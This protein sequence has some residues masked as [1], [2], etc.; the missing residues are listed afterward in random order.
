MDDDA[1][2]PGELHIHRCIFIDPLLVVKHRGIKMTKSR[3]ISH[4]SSVIPNRTLEKGN[5]KGGDSLLNCFFDCFGL[6]NETNLGES[7]FHVK[8]FNKKV[9]LHLNMS[10]VTFGQTWDSGQLIVTP[11]CHPPQKVR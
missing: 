6:W 4:V 11:R 2:P 9:I 5:K 8:Y 3:Q 1:D 10:S 7:Y